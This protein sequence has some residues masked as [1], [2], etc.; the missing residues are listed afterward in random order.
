ML[1]A[2]YGAYMKHRALLLAPALLAAFVTTA[3]TVPSSSTLQSASSAWQAG[4][5]VRALTIH[6][7]L[8][9]SPSADD[10]L[11][12]IALETGELYSTTE[13]TADG[14]APRFSPDGRLLAYEV[15]TVAPARTILAAVAAPRTSVLELSGTGV[16]F[17]PDGATMAYLRQAAGPP[18]PPP[19]AGSQ[20]I[21]R[22]TASGRETEL[23]PAVRV[24]ALVAGSGG[25]VIFSGTPVSGGTAQVYVAAEGRPP[26]PLTSGGD[27]DRVIGALNSTATAAIFT[28]RAGRGGAGRGGPAAAGRGA[29]GRGATPPV[30][31]SFGVISLGDGRTTMVNGSA[32]AFSPDGTTLAYVARDGDEYRLTIAPT[33]TPAAGSVV[34]A[35]RERIDVPAWSPDGTRLAYQLMAADDWEIYVV[36]R[37]GT[38]ETR[39]TREIQHDV[40]PRFL[41]ATR[42]LATMGEPRHRRSYLYDLPSGKRTRL[43]H[44]NTVRTIAPEYAWICSPDGARVLIGAERDGDTVSPQRG[45]YLV[46][47]TRR[48][49]RD[50]VR[51]RVQASL[52]G[53]QALA[54]QARRLYAPI[55]AT[56]KDVVARASVSRVYEYEK[57][58]FDFD[59]KYITQPGNQ[60]ASEFLFNTYTSFG[61]QPEYQWFEPRNVP[62]RTANVLATLTGTANPELVYV[63]SSHYDSVAIGPGA[64]D[65]SSGTAALLETARILAGH[66]QP[67]TI[68]FASF[69]GE[70][71]GLLGSREFVR[72]EVA[73]KVHIVGAL[74]ND[75]IGWANDFRLDNTIRYSN[76][77]IRDVQHAAAMLFTSLI[78]Y[79]SLYYKSTDAAAY[80]DAFGDIV[81]GI[82]S[83]PVLGNPHYHQSHDLLET[84][85]H[86]LVT[87]VAKTTAASV[88]LLASSPS[89]LTNVKVDR[90]EGGTA[91][92]S[93]APSPEKG[94]T[95]YLVAYGPAERPEARRLRV[96]TPRVALPGVAAGT[97]VAVKAVNARG[98][99]GWDWAR[100]MVK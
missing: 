43:F 37:D 11:E 13:L 21:I 5:Y 80:Y 12:P 52:V 61:Y 72:R 34:R 78:T 70:E 94:V 26:A 31:Q 83:Y 24:T 45:V 20:I 46:D 76:R 18:S 82:G 85:N 39:V 92:V 84:I 62:V 29:G 53:E 16:T 1:R 90:F 19:A 99:E 59:S 50:E 3:A 51:A 91:T 60:R 6:L 4:D 55:A 22:D 67:A 65:D 7:Q 17:S 69:T 25:T 87:E 33:I 14:T 40:L 44:N 30:P 93:W 77:G 75:M 86:Q 36:N 100:V 66:P 47:L 27:I 28:L 89:R 97:V 81:G 49:T 32:P 63:V 74:N 15:P 73:D 79:D 8:L 71:G 64:D 98:L 41:T 38:G 95:G 56:V 96:S 88:M 10:V 42:L 54:A 48:V 57:T 2:S 23:A 68:V 58:L 35:G 9:D